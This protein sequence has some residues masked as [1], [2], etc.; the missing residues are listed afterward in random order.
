MCQ[1]LNVVP[2]EGMELGEVITKLCLTLDCA[3]NSLWSSCRGERLCLR[4]KDSSAF[5]HQK[6]WD[7]ADAV[8]GLG[9]TCCTNPRDSRTFQ[10][11]PD[12]LKMFRMEETWRKKGNEP[13]MMSCTISGT[14]ILHEELL[15]PFLFP[16]A[17]AK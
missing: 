4:Q 8:Q 10:A 6:P 2:S 13:W 1:T 14:S 15:I 5:L 16:A 7:E 12:E 17:N 3:R 9:Q 11:S